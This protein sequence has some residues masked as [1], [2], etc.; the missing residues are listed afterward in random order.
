M[1]KMI[2][3]LDAEGK[4]LLNADGTPKMIEAPDDS[5]PANP[6]ADPPADPPAQSLVSKDAYDRVKK[7][8][9]DYKTKNADLERRLADMKVQG[10][11]EKEDWKSV[12]EHHE[13]EA[14][15]LKGQY[16]GLKNSLLSDKKTSALTAE[17]LKQGINPA[18]L[19]DLE[20]LDFDELTVETTSTGKILVSGADRA[21]AK[22]K[23]LR[24]HWF[25]KTTPSVNP[26][27]PNLGTPQ[28]GQVTTADLNAAETQW[29]KTKSEADRKA[30]YDIIQRYKAQGG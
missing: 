26:S 21:I 5:T 29:K 8:M 6:P 24:P 25:T 2:P 9:H 3:A 7:D 19:P 30:Y 10:H 18:S 22:L 13:N 11:K 1:P 27:T 28:S 17:A 16:E 23:T 20:L 12:A 4:P 14:K 15:T